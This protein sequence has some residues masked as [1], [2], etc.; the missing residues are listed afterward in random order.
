MTTSKLSTE[1]NSN[2]Y[3]TLSLNQ[4]LDQAIDYSRLVESELG[5][6][7]RVKSLKLWRSTLIAIYDEIEPKM[8]KKE[9]LSA[10]MMFK[11]LG[12]IGPVVIRKNTPDGPE[13]LID[14]EKLSRHW[15]QLNKIGRYLRRVA[16]SKG[17]LL[18]N[19]AVDEEI[20]EMN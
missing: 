2:Q 17:M 13:N 12:K 10:A 4:L 8:V 19:K 9:K 11:L 14:P 20:G 7:R 6:Y 18:T 5:F 1:W 3:R 16:D 15:S